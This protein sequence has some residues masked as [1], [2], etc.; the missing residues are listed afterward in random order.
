M[1]NLVMATAL[2]MSLNTF[3]AVAMLV[4]A[5]TTFIRRKVEPFSAP[6]RL[7]VDNAHEF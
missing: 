4:G 3:S 7:L 2:A 5:A 6:G 1:K